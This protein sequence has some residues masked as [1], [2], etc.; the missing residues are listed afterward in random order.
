LNQ[1]LGKES[2][3]EKGKAGPRRFEFKKVEDYFTC[4]DVGV[5]MDVDV[6]SGVAWLARDQ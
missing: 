1:I 3:K 4:L 2:I 5:D 6:G